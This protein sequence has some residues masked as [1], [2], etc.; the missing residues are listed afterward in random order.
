MIDNNYGYIKEGKV[1]R[2]AF[3]HFPDR[4]IGEVK[5]SEEQAMKYFE[6]RFE[7]ASAEVEK[8]KAKINGT[9]NK[10]SYLMKVLHLKETLS[11]FDAIGDFESLYKILNELHDQLQAI[12][13]ANRKKNLEIKTALL[14]QL[15]PIAKSSDWK[16]SSLAIK[17]LKSK[18]IKT[19]AVAE[20][21]KEEI[22]GQFTSLVDSFYERRNSFYEDLNKMMAEKEEDFKLFLKEVDLKLQNIDS[23][24]LLL[25]EI[26]NTVERWKALG[27][28][29]RTKHNEY[30]EELQSIF[31][32]N[33]QR[34]KKA[35]SKIK[36]KSSAEIENQKQDILDELEKA[37]KAIVPDVDLKAIKERWKRSGRLGKKLDHEFTQKYRFFLDTISEKL[38]LNQLL[39]KKAKST[40]TDAE[41][42][43]LRVRLMYDL[44]K[45]DQTELHNFEE[46]LGKFNTASGLNE[47]LMA[48]LEHQKR[49]VEVKKEIINELKGLY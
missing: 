29:E 26:K 40:H 24:K 38:F 36:K 44:L 46:N 32:T 41:K 18:W 20:D 10:G 11:D 33:T 37:S 16:A 28:L 49:K 17:E 7:Q 19:G 48:K 27:K 14:E 45:R 31:K 23:H 8:V 2:K 3:L 30:W 15:A 13:D 34:A 21:K 1:F 39:V 12:I 22:E 25:T 9:E 6:D 43:K 47:V 42:N 4:E 5:E 35:E